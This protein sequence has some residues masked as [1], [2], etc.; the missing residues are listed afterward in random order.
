MN[1]DDAKKLVIDF[2]RRMDLSNEQ[3]EQYLNEAVFE[4][5]NVGKYE[6]IYDPGIPMHIETLRT[7]NLSLAGAASV[8][9]ESV[10]IQLTDM[11]VYGA[12]FEE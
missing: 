6:Y 1:P 8:T 12:D 5:H 7:V 10:V 3:F 2:L 9:S 4:I 11:K